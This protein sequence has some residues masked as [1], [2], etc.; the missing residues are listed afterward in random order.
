VTDDVDAV[1]VLSNRA[2]STVQREQQR[3]PFQ[4]S[5]VSRFIRRCLRRSWVAHKNSSSMAPLRWHHRVRSACLVRPRVGSG[6]GPPI[7]WVGSSFTRVGL[8]P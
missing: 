7:G 4:K 1:V 5:C 2:A 6:M 3:V 8:G